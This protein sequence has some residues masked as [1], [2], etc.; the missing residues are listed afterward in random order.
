[1]TIIQEGNLRFFFQLTLNQFIVTAQPTK[2]FALSFRPGR[3]I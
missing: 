2:C 1:M 3:E